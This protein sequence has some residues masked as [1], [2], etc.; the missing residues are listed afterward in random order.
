MANPD[1]ILLDEP[2]SA[3]DEETTLVVES[4]LKELKA[5]GKTLII[6]THNKSV[7]DRLAD[8]I[9]QF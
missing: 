8:E 7:A 5:K 6:V 3:L 2:T 1:V 9:I 4:I